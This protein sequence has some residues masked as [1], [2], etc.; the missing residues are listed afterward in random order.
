MPPVMMTWVTPTAMMPMTETY[1]NM[2]YHVEHRMFPMVPYH[3]LPRLHE[4]I[5]H[6]LPA[7][8]GGFI[9]AYREILPWV[10]AAFGSKAGAAR[11]TRA[12]SPPGICSA[13]TSR[14]PP[15]PGSGP[16]NMS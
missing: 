11:K 3:A 6:D 13:A 4:M 1:W 5:K 10:T 2:N 12:R 7:A 16:T 9:D 14:M 15:C 8:N